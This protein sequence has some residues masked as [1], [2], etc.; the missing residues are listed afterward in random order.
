MSELDDLDGITGASIFKPMRNT[1]RRYSHPHRHSCHAGHPFTDDNLYISPKGM[2]QCRTCNREA[3]KRR[4][5]ERRAEKL[6][7]MLIALL[8]EDNVEIS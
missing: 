5:N 1:K 6:E 7:A 3:H 2:R 8:K 4:E